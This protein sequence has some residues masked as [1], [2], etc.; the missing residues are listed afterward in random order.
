MTVEH[1][2]GAVFVGLIVIA[3]WVRS[4]YRTWL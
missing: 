2:I 1:V 4:Q 3:I